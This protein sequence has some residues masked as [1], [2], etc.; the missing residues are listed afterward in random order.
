MIRYGVGQIELAKPSIGQVQMNFLAK[1]ALRANALAIAQKQHPDHQ[2]RVNRWTPVVTVV[3]S[4]QRPH[5]RQINKPVNRPQHVIARH[6]LFNRELIKQRALRHLPRSHH[7]IQ[8]PKITGKLNQSTKASSRRLFQHYL[9][10][11][12]S[13]RSRSG[14]SVL[15]GICLLGSDL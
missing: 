14:C 13:N 11:V 9:R 8:S 6:I 7:R 1:S 4:Q 2:F 12:F 5:V 10:I 15:S 3:R